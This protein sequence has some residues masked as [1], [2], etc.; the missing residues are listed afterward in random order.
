MRQARLGTGFAF[1]GAEV[2][3]QVGD[4]NV[5]RALPTAEDLSATATRT[6]R[7]IES[8]TVTA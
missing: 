3:I 4:P 5:R 6:V 8:T 1:V 2:P 7:E